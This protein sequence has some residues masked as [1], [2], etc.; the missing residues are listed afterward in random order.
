MF[1]LKNSFHHPI[2]Y[3]VIRLG[4]QIRELK[5]MRKKVKKCAAI[6]IHILNL[7]KLND[8]Q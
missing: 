6:F 3:H 4:I 8:K 1:C 2:K 7:R 5:I